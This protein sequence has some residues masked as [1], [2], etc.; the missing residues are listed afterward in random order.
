M[1]NKFFLFVAALTILGAQLVRAQQPAPAAASAALDVSNMDKAVKPCQD[2]NAYANGGW[3]AKNPVPDAYSRWGSFDE[4][5]EK[6]NVILHQILEESAANTKARNGS[7]TQKIGDFYASGMDSA[8]I[9]RDGLTPLAGIF[10]KISAVGTKADLVKMIARLHLMGIGSAF[11]A[12]VDQ[13]AK[14][15]T[16]YI[17]DL[18]QG[19]LGLPDRDYY[20]KDD[21]RSVKIREE[22]VKHIASMFRKMTGN[23]VD[24]QSDAK[25]VMAIETRLAN[26]SMSRVD[27]RDPEKMYHKMSIAGVSD[28]APEINWTSYFQTFNVVNPGDV[29]VSHP[30]FFKELSA[31]INDVPMSD[32]KVYLRWNVL[33]AAA[34]KLSDAF[35]NENF[36]FYGKTMTG[37]KELQPRWKRVLALTNAALGEALGQLFV[38]KAFSPAAKTRALEMVNNLIAA[39]KDRVNTLDWMD[40]ATKQAALTKLAA[41]NVKIG[42]PDKWRDYSDLEITRESYVMNALRANEFAVRR[43]YA[44][45]GKPIDRDEWMMTPSTVNAYYNPA[46]NEIVFPA[47]ILQPPFFNADADDAVNYGGIGAVIGH[48]LTHGFDDQGSKYDAEGNMK[49]WWT[50]EVKKQFESRAENVEKQFDQYVAIDSLHVDGKLTLGENI[51][52]LGGLSISYAALQKAF[53]TKTKPGLIDGFTPEQRFFLSW[54]QVWRQNQ[55]PE[56]R[57]LQVKTDPHSPGMFRVRGPIANMKEFED[58]FGCTAADAALRPTTERA[59]IWN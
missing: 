21:E 4:L 15:S 14:N 16:L 29:N 40:A 54:A 41:F 1:R 55:R 3:M 5:G 20:T 32:W 30:P 6:N 56:A 58:A 22:Y 36:R 50:P 44:K 48:E 9:E 47:A 43:E 37:A 26:A 13:D 42:Y 39:F 49:D 46:K 59:K 25:T 51:A 28:I 7:I 53:T 38:Q 19:G 17:L 8:A 23:T 18:D 45:L 10:S 57:R 52:D 2:F 11:R 12:G 31:M 34:P 24:A 35:V 33:R 27:R